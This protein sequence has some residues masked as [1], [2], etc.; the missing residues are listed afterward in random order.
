MNFTKNLDILTQDKKDIKLAMDIELHKE[1]K[2][3]LENNYEYQILSE[4]EDSIYN[5]DE[6]DHYYWIV[7]PLDGSLNYS[8]K[9]PLYCISIALWKLDQP[10]YG[11]IYDVSRNELFRGLVPD[12]LAD[13][14][15]KR[16]S[17][18][19]L[20]KVDKGVLFTGFPSW[21]NYNDSSLYDFNSK[22]QKW[23]K[24]R[25]LGSAALSLAWVSCGRGDAYTE[26]DI[27]IWDVAAG[28]ALVKAAG[29]AIYIN[30]R[31]RKN[32]VTAIATNGQISIQELQ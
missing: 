31:E 17:V 12:K 9:I 18:S 30:K 10:I 1:I 14:N 24:L 11:L 3:F 22:I 20:N 29:G 23:K 15:G 13:N 7:D 5:F 8:R 2:Q 27:R 28:L 26:E 21:R 4:E 25:L 32:F 6:F 16:V 19:S